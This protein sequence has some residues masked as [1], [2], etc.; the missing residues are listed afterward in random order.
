MPYNVDI[1]ELP[2][3]KNRVI[4]INTELIILYFWN[5]IFNYRSYIKN[6]IIAFKF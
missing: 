6:Y 3:Q 4:I 2:V 1:I 5:N